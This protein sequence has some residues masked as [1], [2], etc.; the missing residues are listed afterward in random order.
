MQPIQLPHNDNTNET[1]LQS[2][3]SEGHMST[4]SSRSNI[5]NRLNMCAHWNNPT[6]V[7]DSLSCSKS[8]KKSSH[9]SPYTILT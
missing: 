4:S 7:L 1:S 8:R 3:P 9:Q 2:F 5:V 6:A